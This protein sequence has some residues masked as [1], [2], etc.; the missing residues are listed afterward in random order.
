VA[1]APILVWF[2]YIRS[3]YHARVLTSGETLALPFE[4]PL[5]RLR[6][7]LEPV[8]SAGI[9]KDA[10]LMILV[11]AALC[12]QIG[13]L[14]ARP[15]WRDPWWRLGVAY[16]LLLPFLGKPLWAGQPPTALR[17]LLPLLLAFNVRLRACER[18]A[19]FWTLFVLG[20]ATVI[21]GMIL[22]R[23]I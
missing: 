13:W 1:L 7:A 18:P 23:F 3:I 16:A 10:A 17:V 21:Q 5:W 2:D 14:L 6:Q 11:A 9:T 22:F 15:A 4:G 8:A 19:V 20:N 12:A